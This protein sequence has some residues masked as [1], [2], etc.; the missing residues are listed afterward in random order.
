M[1]PPTHSGCRETRAQ[2]DAADAVG[3]RLRIGQ[4]QRRAPGAATIIQRAMPNFSR[5]IS[6]S[7]IRCG[8]VLSSR[9]PLGRLRPAPR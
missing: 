2:D 1:R 7:A 3:M 8:S 5:M 4:R 9:R 6:M